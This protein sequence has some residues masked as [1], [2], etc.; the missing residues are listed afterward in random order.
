VSEILKTQNLK[1][2]NM[3]ALKARESQE[4]M[5]L[6]TKDMHILA[7]KTKSETV[8]MRIIT[9]VAMFFLPGTFIS[10]SLT[11]YD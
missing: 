9:L 8:S 6:I 2:S 11:C 5:E 7:L 3:L 1:A 10:V 4:S